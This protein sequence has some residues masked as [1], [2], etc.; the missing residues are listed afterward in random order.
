MNILEESGWPAI[1]FNESLHPYS[2]YS[3]LGPKA[4]AA[5]RKK[6]QTQFIGAD[7]YLQCQQAK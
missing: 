7:F 3:A 1:T 6:A 5:A 2:W 4:A